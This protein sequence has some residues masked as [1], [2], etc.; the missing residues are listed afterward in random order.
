MATF[1]LSAPWVIFYREVEAMFKYDTEVHVVYDEAAQTIKLFVEEAD[2][3]AALEALMP[4]EKTF[5]NV[6]LKIE[7]IPANG[8]TD[9]D[10]DE[11]RDILFDFAFEGNAAFAF[12][13][14]IP[15]ATLFTNE[16]TYVVFRKQ[17]VQY[18]TDDLGDYYGQCST[19]YQNI[20][21][22]IFGEIDGVFYCTD[23]EDPVV[24]HKPIVEWP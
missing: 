19:L 7:I 5:G 18:Y 6:T 12:A 17:V 22:D 15:A 8:M 20:A 10:E 23:A 1:H 9:L 2:K 4:S 13:R 21:K 24:L 14:S 3:A 16:L 11:G